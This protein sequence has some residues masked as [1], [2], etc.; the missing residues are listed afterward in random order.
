VVIR[1]ACLLLALP[2]IL[3][4]CGSLQTGG[5]VRAAVARSNP[6]VASG[7]AAA[8]RSGDSVFAGRLLN[9]VAHGN[10]V[11]SPFSVSE[12]LAM[13]LAGARGQTARQIAS[14]LQFELAGARLHAAL[15]RLDREL[16]QISG[17]TIAN[18]LYGQQ[19]YSF[20]SAFLD[21]LA[22]YYGAGIHTVDYRRATE[23]ARAA[24]NHWVSG[25][26]HGKI[27][28]LI[29]AG[30]LDALTR[31]VLVNAVYL[32]AHWLLPFDRAD[33]RAAPFH[34]PGGTIKAPTMHETGT[35]PYLRAT[36]Y[37]AVE[38]PYTGGRLA[39]D[40]LLPDP[41]RLSSVEHRLATTGP[42]GL[43][44]G[45]R[46]ERL[47]LAVPKLTLR[48]HTELKDALS[49]LGMPLAFSGSADLSGIGGRPGDLYLKAVVH[50]AYI[51]VDEHGTEAAAATGA[52]VEATSMPAPPQ[53][54]VNVDRPFVFVLRDTSTGAILFEGVVMDPLG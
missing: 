25:Q 15:D 32:K 26:T 49:A 48:T 2:L 51:R 38:L 47:G 18:A 36:G 50:E 35:L 12:A 23:Q 3:A 27:P 20:R 16:A 53:L 41:G 29:P 54:M 9:G 52:V 6:A 28:Q 11:V 21:L 19:G 30:V 8:L 40:V 7:D 17:L 10:V 1:R 4:G 24:I 37:Q 14:A 33:T 45:L 5:V 44:S 46:P 34:A 39:F 43:L 42:L 13:T 31:L 22:R